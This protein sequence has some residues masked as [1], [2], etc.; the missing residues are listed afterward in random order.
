VLRNQ[1]RQNPNSKLFE[2]GKVYGVTVDAT[3][4]AK[5]ASTTDN[6]SINFTKKK[7]TERMMLSLT[8]T[9]QQTTE[10]WHNTQKT[11][12]NYYTMKAS[13]EAILHRLGID[14][15]NQF[16]AINGDARFAYGMKIHKGQQNIVQ[17]GLL[18]AKICKK[19]DIKQA[20]FYAEFDWETVVKLTK[21][22]KTTFAELPK[23]PSV[24]R[25]LALII[26]KAVSY[27]SIELTVR[28]EAK[29]LLQS[30]NLFDV[31]EQETQVGA[32]KKSYSI[33]MVFQDTEKTLIDKDIDATMQKVIG[34]LEK[35]GAMIK[36][37][38]RNI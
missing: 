35:N 21:K 20:V 34:A 27:Q 1:N 31:Y 32:G 8:M 28:K 6:T 4:T 37:G 17:F 15:N 5:D 16:T 14:G 10:N 23:F 11:P 30:L 22:A 29:K 33:S 24:R 19:M 9:G 7:Y 38:A 18:Q 2:F 12:V 36:G 3:D 13:V 26:D 25:D